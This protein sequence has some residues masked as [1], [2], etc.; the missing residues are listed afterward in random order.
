ML[1]EEC[2]GDVKSTEGTTQ[3]YDCFIVCHCFGDV[4]MVVIL[5]LVCKCGRFGDLRKETVYG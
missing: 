5:L 4:V 1:L 3:N 2:M